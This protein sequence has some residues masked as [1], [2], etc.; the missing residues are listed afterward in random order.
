MS[1]ATDEINL[2]VGEMVFF[3]DEKGQVFPP[4]L[5]GFSVIIPGAG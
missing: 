3:G 5:G 4:T 2:M 1:I